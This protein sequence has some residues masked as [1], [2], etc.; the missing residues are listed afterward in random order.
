MQFGQLMAIAACLQAQLVSNRPP[1][2]RGTFSRVLDG[3][4]FSKI[5]YISLSPWNTVIFFLKSSIA[6][7]IFYYSEVC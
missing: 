5:P 4:Y 1:F 6:R 7:T 3:K 2:S